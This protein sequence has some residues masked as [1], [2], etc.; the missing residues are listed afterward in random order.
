MQSPLQLTFRGMP[1]SPAVEAR[2]KRRTEKLE[3]FHG[4][5]T[6]CHVLVE[7]TNSDHQQGRVYRVGIDLAVPGAEIVAHREAGKGHEHEDVYVAIRDAFSAVAR[8]LGSHTRRRR[9]QVKR[10]AGV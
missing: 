4:R 8:Q 10:H 1:R 2:V 9:G 5:I 6:S 7:S 3:R